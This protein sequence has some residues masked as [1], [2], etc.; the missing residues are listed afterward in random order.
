MTYYKQKISQ[1]EFPPGQPKIGL[2]PK[3]YLLDSGGAGGQ[4]QS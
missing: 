2:S 4:S 1:K 3:G